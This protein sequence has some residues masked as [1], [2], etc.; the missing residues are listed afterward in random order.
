[1]TLRIGVD[2][3]GTFTDL[4]LVDVDSG[5]YSYHKVPSSNDDP[6]RAILDG[7]R[8]LM[9]DAGVG[10][11]AVELLVHGTTVATNAVLQGAWCSTG[12]VVSRGFGDILELARQR[13]PHL[14]DLTV[15]KPVAPSPREAR[16]EV[17]ERLD[18]QGT[19]IDEL[20]IAEV[21]EAIQFLKGKGV[22]SIAVCY[23]HSYRNSV[24]EEITKKRIREA[25][26]SVYVCTSSEV[27]SEFREFERFSTTVVNASLMPVLDAY[28]ERF[29]AGVASIGI[30]ASP[31][32]MQSNG[33]AVSTETV[34]KLPVNT[35]FSGPA[36][37]VIGAVGVAHPH[38]SSDL[39]TFDMGG[40]STDVSLVTGGAP[41][42]KRESEM[43]GFPVRARSLDLHT[44]GAGG[45]SLVWVDPGGLLKVGPASSGAVPGPAAYGRGGDKPTVT[46]ANVLLGRLNPH[47][48]LG[49]RMRV[50]P[51]R[52]K[53][54]F[55]D[56]ICRGTGMSTS[57][58]AIGALR[59]VNVNMMGAVRII[60]VEQG[61]DPRDFTLV[62]FGGAGPLHAAEVALGMGIQRV[63]IPSRPGLLSALGLLHADARRDFSRTE[64]TLLSDES[65]PVINGALEALRRQGNQWLADERLQPD[66]ARFE[67]IAEMRY[68]GQN[69]E[70]P[71]KVDQLLGDQSPDVLAASF[72]RLHN[73]AYG[74]LLEE[75]PIEV[76]GVRLTVTAH[77][78]TPPME[79]A[80]C[81]AGS[82]AKKG[83]RDVWFEATGFVETAVYERNSLPVSAR[84]GG[85]AI[86]E[87]MDTTTVVPPDFVCTVDSTGN[88]LLEFEQYE[89]EREFK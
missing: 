74:Y 44:I 70:L 11:D 57:D 19:V 75:H 36:G 21:D 87:Q 71:V 54:A 84:I 3:G 46:D 58:A 38:G 34:R 51:D 53:A 30:S 78:P 68:F 7:L 76:V 40:T 56:T 12:L 73:D 14:F 35:F 16:W 39:I 83:L 6:S 52:A 60:S 18:Y 79:S 28:L 48:L 63:L 27:L 86:V 25:W 24:H 29:E 43:G 9:A 65:L 45:G 17:T 89:Y 15:K 1:M 72:H 22:E 50:Y 49:G 23:L 61:Q 59:I 32:V 80:C 55:E 33:G 62:A 41:A 20:T 5:Q 66:E 26:P 47:S 77:R 64:L 31:L 13:R 42:T 85:P 8:D 69:F 82:E 81:T 37:G 2:T 88:L 10:A 4:V 67:W